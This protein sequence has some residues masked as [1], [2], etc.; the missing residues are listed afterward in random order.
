MDDLTNVFKPAEATDFT[1]K[2]IYQWIQAYIKGDKTDK[3]PK[4]T[5]K[6]ETKP[7]ETV[8]KKKEFH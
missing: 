3:K 4:K 2:S 1:R 5:E 7:K 6:T 8:D